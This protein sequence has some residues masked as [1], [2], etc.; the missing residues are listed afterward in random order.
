MKFKLLDRYAKRDRLEQGFKWFA[1]YPVRISPHEIAWLE[2]VR[3]RG[4]LYSDGG[5]WRWNYRYEAL[6]VALRE[7]E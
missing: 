2:F 6:Q 5:K 1:W 4:N 3:R 7:R